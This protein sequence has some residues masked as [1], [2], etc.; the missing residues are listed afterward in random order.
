MGNRGISDSWPRRWGPSAMA[1]EPRQAPQQLVRLHAGRVQH[2][3]FTHP[4][5]DG[6]LP[7]V[8]RLLSTG[9]D[10]R[11][12]VWDLDSGQPLWGLQSLS[13]DHLV[14]IGDYTRLLCNGLVVNV[15]TAHTTGGCQNPYHS[16]KHRRPT[17]NNAPSCAAVLCFDVLAEPTAAAE[18]ESRWPLAAEKQ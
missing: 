16:W 5:E 15:S 2:L 11:I 8:L 18:T 3:S 10:G 7:S 17:V 6:A 4:P 13:A 1:A 12:G 14:A 9:A